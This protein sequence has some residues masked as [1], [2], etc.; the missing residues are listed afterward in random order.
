MGCLHRFVALLGFQGDD[1]DPAEITARLGAEPTVAAGKGG[2][3][4]T[5]SAKRKIAA[6]GSWQLEAEDGAPADL[7][8]QIIHLLASLSSDI[9]AWQSLASRYDGRLFCGLFLAGSNAAVT[10]QPATLFMIG[11]RGLVLDLD[12]YARDA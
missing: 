6:T 11:Q 4:L 1:L 9:T 8:G 3:W 12:I 5:S 2:T 7:D 10:L